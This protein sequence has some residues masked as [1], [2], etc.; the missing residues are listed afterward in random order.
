[1]LKG[2]AWPAL[3]ATG[4]VMGVY[5]ATFAAIGGIFAAVDVR[6]LRPAGR[7]S[8]NPRPEGAEQ[9]L[10]RLT[11]CVYPAVR[12][13]GRSREE[14]LL[15]RRDGRRGGR[16]RHRRAGCVASERVRS[17][18]CRVLT[19]RAYPAPTPQRRRCRTASLPRRRWRPPRRWWTARDKTCG[20]RLALA[21]AACA[22]LRLACG[23]GCGASCLPALPIAHAAARLRFCLL[24]AAPAPRLAADALR[25]W[26]AARSQAA[27]GLTTAR[28][29]AASSS[30][31][32]WWR[33]SASEHAALQR[34]SLHT[35]SLETP[36]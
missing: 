1:M 32:T 26:R 2:K 11:R 17:P 13:G 10:T 31:T 4:R 28:R 30:R 33:P 25:S 16:Q 34:C 21:P 23:S 14:G 9:G 29:R 6:A 19:P 3:V 27:A 7:S 22:L 15:E 8:A 18:L 35:P 36:A 20:V 12:G 24:G 5:G